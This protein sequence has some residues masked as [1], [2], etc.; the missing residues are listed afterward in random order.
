MAINGVGIGA[1]MQGIA[2][3]MQLGRAYNQAK[4][5]YDDKEVT[6]NAMA[7]ANASRQSQLEAESARLMGIGNQPNAQASPQAPLSPPDAN[8]VQTAPVDTSMPQATQIPADAGAQATPPTVGGPIAKAATMP[9]APPSGPVAPPTSL[10]PGE[11]NM[12]E[13]APPRSAAAEKMAQAPAAAGG[14][15]PTIVPPTKEEALAQAQKTVPSVMK[16]FREQGVPKIAEAYLANGDAAKAQAW[17]DW[18]EKEDTQQHMKTWAKAW[19]A[20]QMG[21]VEGA[22]DHIFDLY[23]GYSDGV[24]PMSKE[25]VKDNDGNVTGFNVKLKVDGSGEERSTFIGRDQ[26]L[27]MGVSSLAPPQ[28]FEME[29]KNKQLKDKQAAEA[30]LEAGKAKTKLASDLVLEKVKQGGRVALE[31]AQQ[32][33]R[34]ALAG[35]NSDNNIKR[36]NNR[37][38]NDRTTNSEKVTNEI[39]AK[40]EALQAAGYSQDFIRNALPSLL[41][42]GEYK[43]ATSPEEAK[44][45]MF[46]ERM[47]SD[48]TFASMEPSKQR[49][50]IDGDMNL[51][52]GGKEGNQTGK[53][54]N[55]FAGGVGAAPGQRPMY[56]T[57]TGKVVMR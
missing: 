14:L 27:E 52:Y 8:G 32:G 5:E 6:K 37:A 2:Q 31:D 44:R 33:N 40:A 25:V 19:R 38:T 47:K 24:T 54:S 30:A 4:S 17:T 20:A 7:D 3:G 49:E 21:D 46:S 43:R 15:A 53:A 51:V 11:T 56:D 45:L 41:G 9:P 23:K 10:A 55:P 22:A 42:A 28:M 39:S 36:D 12:N 13:P 29:Y 34:V 57:K 26:L 50:V 48:P 1:F 35:I 16:I 18:A